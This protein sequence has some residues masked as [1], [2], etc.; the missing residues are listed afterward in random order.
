MGLKNY[1][2]NIFQNKAKAAECLAKKEINGSK[3]K[4]KKEL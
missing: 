2:P 3:N 1:P 4:L